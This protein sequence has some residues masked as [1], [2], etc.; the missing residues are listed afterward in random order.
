MLLYDHTFRDTGITVKIRKV[1][2]LLITDID[3]AMPKPEP[4]M[5]E[6]DYGEPRGKV[7]EPNLSEPGYLRQL[8]ERRGRVWRAWRRAVILRGVV[9]EG[10]D[11]KGEVE[12]YRALV[13][14]EAGSPLDEEEDWLVYVL[15]IC[16]GSMEDLNEL[17]QDITNRSGPTEE[18]IEKAK[19]T[20]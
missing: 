4:P 13:A 10:D 15:R 6:V 16:V 1:S 3:D 8:D 12:A 7:Q 19:A 5:Q 11:W 2:P 20:F 9:P 14:Q 17:I 18:A